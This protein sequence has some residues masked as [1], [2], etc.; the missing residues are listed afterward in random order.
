MCIRDSIKSYCN[1]DREPDTNSDFYPK[2]YTTSDCTT[3]FK[4]DRDYKSDNNSC[5]K[6]NCYNVSYSK[7]YTCLLYTSRCV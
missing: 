5:N 4:S 6:P 2:T 3:N 7:S 1:S